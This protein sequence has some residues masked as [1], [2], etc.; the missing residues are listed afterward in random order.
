M[1]FLIRKSLWLC[2]LLTFQPVCCGQ[3]P[4]APTRP[5]PV[6]SWKVPPRPESRQGSVIPANPQ[7]REITPLQPPQPIQG[8]VFGHRPLEPLPEPPVDQE[9]DL[10][11]TETDSPEKPVGVDP[12]LFRYSIHPIVLSPER[13]LSVTGQGVAL[14]EG[15]GIDF[16]KLTTLYQGDLVE[17]KDTDDDWHQVVISSG[18][19]GWISTQLTEEVPQ[20]VA[21]VAGERVNLRDAPSEQARIVGSLYRGAVVTAME[22]FGD[23]TQVRTPNL[24]NVYIATKYLQ[25]ME[26]KEVP[27]FPL[28]PCSGSVDH[29]ASLARLG[30][31]VTGEVEYLLAVQPGDWVKG[32]KVG[33]I[34]LS[35][36]SRPFLDEPP[37]PAPKFMSGVFFE[38]LL[39][40]DQFATGFP[41]VSNLPE[42]IT[43]ILVAYLRGQ[44]ENRVW[45]FPFKF[46]PGSSEGQF[47][48]CCQEGPNAGAY[49]PLPITEVK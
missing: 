19:Q 22:I 3:S 33:L 1:F 43:S 18:T 8:P 29:V 24:R 47:G 48:L 6:Q 14:R 44:K 46:S 26:E 5:R 27:P 28:Q 45:I 49:I 15:P 39:Y 40:N 36:Y 4:I 20:R 41:G 13:Y 34:Y 23:W 16:R 21:V 7:P 30:S 38:R 42:S 31:S 35:Q 10:G 25:M 11:E 32:G 12:D 17:W 9:E 2:G 37:E